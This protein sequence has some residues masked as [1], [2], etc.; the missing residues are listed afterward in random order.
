MCKTFDTLRNDTVQVVLDNQ[1]FQAYGNCQGRSSSLFEIM[2]IVTL[3][4]RTPKIFQD[5]KY[6]VR[7]AAAQPLSQMLKLEINT[8]RLVMRHF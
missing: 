6:L 7:R 4:V 8:S 3:A 2:Q 5:I 1:S